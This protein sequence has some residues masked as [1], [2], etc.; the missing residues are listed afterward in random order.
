MRNRRFFWLCSCVLLTGFCLLV[1]GGCGKKEAKVKEEK[2]FN[3]QIG[4][5]EKKPL[6][7]FI[8]AIGTL[9]AFEEVT[10]SAEIEGIL[11]SVRVDEGSLV[12]KG[13]LLATIDDTDYSHEVKRDEAAMKQVEATLANTR[14][15]YQRKD[16]LHKEELV[17]KQQFDDVVTRLSL[18]E[19]EI[20]RAKAALSIARQKLSKTKV[21]SPISCVVKEKKVSAGDFVKNGTP[22]F[23]IIQPN[24]IKLRFSV[25]EKD[26]GKI[27]KNQDVLVKVDAFPGREFKGKVSTIYPSLE[28]RTRT[29]MVEALVPNEQGV[30]KP[31]LFSKVV[32]YTG[33]VTDTVVVPI[34]ALLYEAEKVK[35]F[36]VEGDR[37][38]ER[39]LKPGSKYGEFM[40]IIEGL[41]EGEK[42]VTAGQ[43]NL[44]TGVKVRSQSSAGTKGQEQGTRSE[45]RGKR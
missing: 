25:A 3:V 8:E 21:Y 20:D 19:A 37:A 14:I 31:G 2:T 41:K 11:K 43:Q 16:A 1:T 7:P 6:R 10:V 26:I 12:P 38:K 28:E 13:M 42:V 4:V 22:L 15:E 32:L 33:S 30:L 36:V 44:S 35:V 18:A 23:T 39:P 17:T 27:V 9:H 34:T 5:A 45:D 24:P 29:L 40:E